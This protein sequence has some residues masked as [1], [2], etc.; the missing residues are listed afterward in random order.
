MDFHSQYKHRWY[1]PKV[2]TF[3][4]P[5]AGI[6]VVAKQDI[7]K[8][9]IVFVYG[10][11]II[12]KSEIKDYWKKMGHAGIQVDD[13]F[14]LCPISREELKEQGIINHSC[15]PNVG[16]KNSV[17]LVAIKDIKSGEEI[18]LDY[19]FCESA[20]ESFKCNCGSRNCRKMITSEDWKNK[21]LQKKFGDYFSPYL[22]NHFYSNR[23]GLKEES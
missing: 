15:E 12:P 16:F 6:G 3:S 14:F 1:S 17:V 20:K 4:S 8:G 2:K 18:V 9:E 5:I 23:D 22:K 21:D 11:V 7:V 19:A 10:G 13:E